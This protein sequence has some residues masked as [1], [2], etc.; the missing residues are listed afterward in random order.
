[1]TP[2]EYNLINFLQRMNKR[3]IK[4]KKLSDIILKRFCNMVLSDPLSSVRFAAM[5]DTCGGAITDRDFYDLSRYIDNRLVS[6]MDSVPL[7]KK[8]D[9]MMCNVMDSGKSNTLSEKYIKL[10]KKYHRDGFLF[11]EILIPKLKRAKSQKPQKFDPVN[12]F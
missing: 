6:K 12:L 4:E 11:K 1:M 5:Y 10:T 7:F 2:C 3:Y 8:Y 9:D